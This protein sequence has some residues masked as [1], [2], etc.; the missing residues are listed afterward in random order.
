LAFEASLQKLLHQRI[1]VPLHLV[2]RADGPHLALVDDRD[3]VRHAKSEVP[4]VRD[5]QRGDPDSLLEAHNLLGNDHGGKRVQ[6]AGRLIVENQLRLDDQR[7]GDGHALLHAAGKLAGHFILRAGQAHPREL[8]RG[9]AGDFP[10]R[11][12]PVFGQVQADV[13][14]DRQRI[15][16]RAGLEDHRHAV[17]IHNPRRLQGL[18]FEEDF[19]GV[20]RFQPDQVLEQDGFAAAAGAHDDENLARRHLEI[21][22]AQNFLAVERLAQPAHAQADAVGLGGGRVHH[23]SRMRVR[24]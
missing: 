14:P 11:P 17:T 18:A 13:L 12:Q 22:A 4:V 1:R 7:P 2:R 8:F 23:F 3:A 5:N 6:L 24:K 15:Q 20:R 21:Q 19:P 16:Q 10:G 9:D